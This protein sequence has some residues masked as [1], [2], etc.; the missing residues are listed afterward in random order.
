MIG[1]FKTKQSKENSA[2]YY[3]T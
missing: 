2:L 3:D 1:V